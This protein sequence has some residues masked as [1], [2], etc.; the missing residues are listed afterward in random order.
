MDNYKKDII[1]V[2]TSAVVGAV[3][4]LFV[5]GWKE[6]ERKLDEAELKNLI[7]DS[8]METLRVVEG[9]LVD[10]GHQKSELELIIEQSNKSS[11]YINSQRAEVEF[12][13]KNLKSKTSISDDDIKRLFRE[14]INREINIQ[15]SKGLEKINTLPDNGMFLVSNRINCPEGSMEIANISLQVSK[16][17][18]ELYNYTKSITGDTSWDISKNYD[19]RIFKTCIFN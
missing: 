18:Q 9:L 5:D 7:A 6:S 2:F 16:N 10:I 17:V 14:E 15:V 13:V 3:L 12:I 11:E 19:G 4:A 1:L 8:K